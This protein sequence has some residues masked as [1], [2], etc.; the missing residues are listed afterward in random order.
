MQIELNSF[1]AIAN[2]SRTE[3]KTPT[4]DYD[5]FLRL[6]VAELKTQDPTEPM[7]SAQYIGQLASFSNVEQSIK[8]N[9]KIDSLLTMQGLTQAAS[10]VGRIVASP[11]GSVQG[12]VERVAVSGGVSRAFLDTGAELLISDGFNVKAG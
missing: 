2:Q 12:R 1:G 10:L 7:D 9:S 8:L 4:L 6:L 11:D 3:V 5:A